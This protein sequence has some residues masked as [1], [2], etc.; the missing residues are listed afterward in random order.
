MEEKNDELIILHKRYMNYILC[1]W[2]HGLFTQGPTDFARTNKIHVAYIKVRLDLK[3]ARKLL[4]LSLR[5]CT[6]NSC[7]AGPVTRKNSTF[8]GLANFH[9][10]AVKIFSH[11]YLTHPSADRK[12]NNSRGPVNF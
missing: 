4:F 2:G 6:S 11:F 10:I 7:R 5:D 3:T 1:L 8:L 9:R 12:K